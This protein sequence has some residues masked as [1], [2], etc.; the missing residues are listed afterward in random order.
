[1]A[2]SSSAGSWI[3]RA[4]LVYAILVLA[5]SVAR[6][7]FADS[8]W[9]LWIANSAG[10]YLFLPIPVLATL[11][12]LRRQWRPLLLLAAP[13]AVFGLLYGALFLP[14]LS[15]STH[16]EVQPLRVITF[17]VLNSNTDHDAVTELILAQRA[18]LVALQELIPANSSAIEP[19][20]TSQMYPYHTPLPVEHRLDVG[21]FSRFPIIE[22]E[23]LDLPWNDLSRHAVVDI[24]GVRVHVFVLHLVPTLLAQAPI[25]S[26]PDRI[27]E[28]EA[29]RMDQIDR[30][31]GALP[32]GDVPV[33]VLCDCNFT[34]TTAA[35]ARFAGRL[36]DA[37]KEVGW[38]LGHTVHPAS[39][40]IGF[41]RIDYVWHSHHFVARS[42]KVT[43]GGMSDHSP[44]V[45]DL[46][47]LIDD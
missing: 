39:V 13:A 2:S 10:K 18:D 27:A 24:D 1:M 33:L 25:S 38:G 43:R 23:K 37:F 9:L 42:A 44:V 20:L 34:E 17:N 19:T 12:T 41:N 46:E 15:P 3:H 11:L 8:N 7:I 47:L 32:E 45:A 28:R 40:N 35:Y 30:V 4:T 36:H 22:S 31:L 5:W 21:L 29:I 6:A 16:G 26:W 14:N